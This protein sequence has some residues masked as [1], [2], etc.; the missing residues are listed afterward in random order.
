MGRYQ[1]LNTP[2]GSRWLDQWR[3]QLSNR[4]GRERR[5]DEKKRNPKKNLFSGLFSRRACLLLLKPG[6]AHLVSVSFVFLNCSHFISPSPSSPRHGYARGGFSPCSARGHTG[7]SALSTALEKPIGFQSMGIFLF[8]CSS[9]SRRLWSFLLGSHLA[10]SSRY[11]HH[12][13]LGLQLGEF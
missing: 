7:R 3:D 11:W 9:V 4:I 1:L 5:D 12:C 13:S 10:C 6:C 8:R 2:P